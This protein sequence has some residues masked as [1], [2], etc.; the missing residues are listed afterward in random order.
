MRVKLAIVSVLPLI[1]FG[2]C[3][4]FT[5]ASYSG[6]LADFAKKIDPLYSQYV[7][8]NQQLTKL[9]AT[10]NPTDSGQVQ[11]LMARST[12]FNT[13][14][15]QVSAA[16]DEALKTEKG[17]QISFS[18][19]G[20]KEGFTMNSITFEGA[21]AYQGDI[22]LHFE[23][24]ATLNSP[25]QHWKASIWKFVDKNGNVLA[26]DQ[27]TDTS[28]ARSGNVTYYGNVMGLNELNK[29]FDHIVIE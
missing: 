26:S 9:S 1:L 14:G 19:T 22:S 27:F 3:K 13:L 5:S 11:K 4:H 21:F 20:S 18:Q 29:N 10:V 6:P 23:G 7:D 2:G 12:K 15:P 8:T 24:H 17:K 16:V 28:N 25:A